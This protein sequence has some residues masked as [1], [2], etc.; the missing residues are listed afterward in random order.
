MIHI[1][2]FFFCALKLYRQYKFV[3]MYIQ[4]RMGVK[5]MRADNNIYFRV[6]SKDKE[7]F[8]RAAANDD[9]SLSKWL[10]DLAYQ[11]IKEQENGVKGNLLN[12]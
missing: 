3:K 2:S 9:L 5:V 8:Q 10:K 6:S 7:A 4:R 11:R 12:D 1:E